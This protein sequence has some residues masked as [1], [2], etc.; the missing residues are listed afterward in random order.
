MREILVRAIR[1]YGESGQ[2]DK[3]IEEASELIK[4]LLKLRYAEKDYEKEIC[5][6]AVTEEM[7][8]VEI[9]L[10]QLVIIFQNRS[11]MDMKRNEKIMRLERR[12]DGKVY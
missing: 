12:L 11:K 6:D 9:M 7:A 8:D 4:A 2:I 10:D 5:M 3:F 1:T